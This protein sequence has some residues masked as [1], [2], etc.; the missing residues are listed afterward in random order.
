[1]DAK[2]KFCF[3][4]PPII[5]VAGQKQLITPG[6]G[7]VNALDPKT[8]TEIWHF[9]Y[10]QGYSVV[11]RPVYAPGMIYIGTGYDKPTVIAIQV[12]AE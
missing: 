2:K 4:T 9:N 12:N 11:P 5:D 3:C 6:S 1:S 7:V 10:D 8:G